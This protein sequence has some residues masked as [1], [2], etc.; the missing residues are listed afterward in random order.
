LWGTLPSLPY[1][2]LHY[3]HYLTLPYIIAES[4]SDDETELAK[5]VATPT[6]SSHILD[7]SMDQDSLYDSSMGSSSLGQS[8]GGGGVAGGVA[9]REGEAEVPHD[10]QVEGSPEKQMDS[11]GQ[12]ETP[13]C[14]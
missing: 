3:L 6:D 9:G 11:G 8:M 14:K 2:T 10:V 5:L 1:I 7:S 12:G 13:S 4:M